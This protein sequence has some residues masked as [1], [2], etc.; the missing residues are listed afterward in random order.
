MIIH[1]KKFKYRLLTA[2]AILLFTGV[3]LESFAGRTAG[4]NISVNFEKVKI[5]LV[6][7]AIEAQSVYQ[8]LYKNQLLADDM[9]VAICVHHAS[10]ENVL[11]KILLHNLLAY[12]IIND[13]HVLI[14]QATAPFLVP[15]KGR[16]ADGKNKP[17]AGVSIQE[18]GT[19]N[20]VT[21]REDGSFSITVSNANAVLLVSHIGYGAKEVNIANQANVSIQLESLE[22][23]MQQVVVIGYGTQKRENIIGS[24]SQLSS[25]RLQSRPVTQLANALSGQMAGVTVIQRSGQ[26]GASAGIINVRGVGSFG[27]SSGALVIV[28]GI[29]G[30]LNDIDPN[31]V[32][33]ISVL[34]DASSA[35]I[36]GARAANGVILVSTK[37][38]KSGK[39]KISYNSYVGFQKPTAFP[40][41]LDSWDYAAM[42]NEAAPGTYTTDDIKKFRDGSDPD[43]HPNTNF[44]KAVFSKDGLQTGHNLTISSGS[45]NTQYNLSLGYLFQDGLVVKNNYD[46]YNIRL[47]LKQA[48]NSKLD[49]TTRL[50]AIKTSD[51]EPGP[52]ATLD[53]DGVLGIINHAVRYP[54]TNAAKLSNGYYGTGVVQKGTP[55]SFLESESFNR[56]NALNL[57]ANLRLDYK[58]ISGL[59]LSFI[60]AYNQFNTKR[61]EFL[62][63]QVI[64]PQITLGPNELNIINSSTDYYTL[65]GLA[66][67]SKKSGNHQ[68]GILAGYSFED[69]QYEQSRAYRNRLPG[70]ELIQLNVGSPD[71][72]QSGGTGNEWALESFFGRLN[73]SYANKYLIE[74]VVR[75]DGSSR[76][77]ASKKYAYFPSAAIGYRMGEEKF[78]KQHF[79]WISELKLKASFGILGNQ[80][81]PNYPYQNT[82]RLTNDAGG[83]FSY[84]FGGVIN[85]GVARTTITDPNLHWESTRTTDFGMELGLLKGKFN[86][87]ATY[88]DRYSYDILYSP[89]GSVSST[90]GFSLSKQN[91]GKLSNKGWEFIVS[92]TNT[93]GSFRYN[94]NG[95][96]SIIN[97]KVL[98][99]GVGNINQ[100]NGMIGNGSSLFIG[101]PMQIYY[102]YQADGIFIDA[103]DV[104]NYLVANNQSAI[105]PTAQPGDVRYKDI[106]G[107]GGKPDGKVDATY[108]RVVLGS[109]IP[110]YTFGLN[111]GAGFKGFDFSMLLQGMAGVKNYMN[112]YAGI[113]FN[114]FGSIQKWQMDERWSPLNP[115]RD[116]GYP[117]LELVT[118]SG[119]PNTLL[120]SFWVL[121]GSYLRGKN[122]QIGY[123]LAGS[124]IKRMKVTSIRIYASGENLFLFSNYR[125]GWDPEVGTDSSPNDDSNSII[126]SGSYYPILKNYTFGLNINF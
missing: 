51:R 84:P 101:Y 63:T 78:I 110:K 45:A 114:N 121:N 41:F 83:T 27:A 29:P 54:S 19:N 30:S 33:S 40:E 18:K 59:K 90:L 86:L 37:S 6:L 15:V 53:L 64:N 119:T 76:F 72:Q 66:E 16:I 42:Y 104:K 112:G 106:S 123:T 103:E 89:G 44:L 88:F 93:I 3:T 47:N 24:V 99:L 82:Y 77:P 34:K 69:N 11:N 21:S 2:L 43:N 117:R 73:Y 17:I 97:N 10:L 60:T 14:K 85:Q 68:I 75:R 7:K 50:S 46:R 28:D 111:I 36:Y 102:G 96:F 58:V 81:I 61:K 74:G 116:A 100:P 70:N 79:T 20:G 107:P 105:N 5:R 39:M 115:R 95:N 9:Q 49:L 48:L 32:E 113:A 124:V 92:H 118:N 108:D 125:K 26:P 13:N 23:E 1:I 56:D 87:A 71:N 22:E 4:D 122:I 94:F 98:D 52:P 8:F 55:V 25:D 38:G 120:S 67:Y 62:S 31:D 57:N 65:Q 91:T 80:N 109:N 126:S 12:E 35:A